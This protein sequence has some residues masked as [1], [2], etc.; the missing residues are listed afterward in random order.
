MNQLTFFQKLKN[1]IKI[2]GKNNKILVDG[3]LKISKTKIVIKGSNN[4]LHIKS[5]VKINGSFIEGT[6]KIHLYS[7]LKA[8]TSFFYALKGYLDF[9]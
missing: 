3:D 5:G 6:S 9:S 4:T 7:S 8:P 1:R 2:S